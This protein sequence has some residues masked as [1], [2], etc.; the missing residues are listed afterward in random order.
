MLHFW[1]ATG[2]ADRHAS[3]VEL[4]HDAVRHATLPSAAV[5]EP[6]ATPN[7]SPVTVTLVPP[8]VARLRV[9][10]RVALATGASYLI[11]ET[12]GNVATTAEI[13][14]MP[15][16]TTLEDV[17][18]VSELEEDQAAVEHATPAKRTVPLGAVIPKLR[19]ETV[20]EPPDPDSGT[21]REITAALS[22]GASNV[23]IAEA[24][25][26]L[27][28]MVTT[29]IL[30]HGVVYIPMFGGNAHSSEVELVHCVVRHDASASADVGS[31]GSNRILHH[32]TVMSCA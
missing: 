2:H 30:S 8:L 12:V 32:V 29:A 27:E 10:P 16:G 4:V 23:N 31:V 17:S 18:H 3:V 22:T 6:Y 28:P 15:A 5:G 21:F 9:P 1:L 25:A 11:T 7:D 20:T 19:P 24:V 13:V 14:I 26:I